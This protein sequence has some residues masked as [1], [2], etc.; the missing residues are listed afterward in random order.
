MPDH[1]LSCR[2]IVLKYAKTE[3]CIYQ[4]S[5]YRNQI[6]SFSVGRESG[7]DLAY[8]LRKSVNRG[9]D[10]P[11]RLSRLAFPF[12]FLSVVVLI[13]TQSGV[14]YGV[15]FISKRVHCSTE[16]KFNKKF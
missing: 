10:T 15:T 4:Y 9:D 8:L 6:A 7:V 1:H 14:A 11:N 3:R 16:G 12:Q 5:A 13:Q 2:L